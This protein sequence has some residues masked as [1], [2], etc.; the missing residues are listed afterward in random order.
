M[1][2]IFDDE[3]TEEAR[4]EEMRKMLTEWYEESIFLDETV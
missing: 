1:D 4:A 2:K 3:E